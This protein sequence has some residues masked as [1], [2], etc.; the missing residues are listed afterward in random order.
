MSCIICDLAD[1]SAIQ[2]KYYE[3]ENIVIVQNIRSHNYKDKQLC[4]WK[5]HKEKLTPKELVTFINT[6]LEIRD[7]LN[8]EEPWWEIVWSMRSQPQHFHLHLARLDETQ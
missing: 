1:G 8:K 3:D 4:I 7:N 5:E 2:E 6:L